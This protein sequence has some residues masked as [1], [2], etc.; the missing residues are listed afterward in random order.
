LADPDW[1]A[2]RAGDYGTLAVKDDGP[3]CGRRSVHNP[4]WNTIAR[5]QSENLFSDDH[6]TG[7]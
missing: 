7:A 3:G 1:V 4:S 5:N 6:I 2:S